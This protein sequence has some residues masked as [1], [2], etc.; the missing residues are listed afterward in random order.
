MGLFARRRGRA[1]TPE[2]ETP[3]IPIP[4]RRLIG[5]VRPYTGYMVIAFVA[6]VLSSLLSLV[7][8]AMIQRVVD[9]VLIA[10]DIALLDQ[11][12]IILLGVFL[13]RALTQLIETYTINY[14]GE[15]IVMNLR[16]ELYAHIVSLSLA[17]FTK[18]RAGELISRLSSDVTMIRQVLTDNINTLL[19][20]ILIAI[21][22]VVIMLA[23]NWR[24]TLFILVLV[25]ILGAIGGVI[26]T[27]LRRASTRIQDEIAGA[28]TVTTEVIQNIREVKTFVREP[29][30][31]TRYRT[32]IQ[33]AFNVAL[34]ALRLRSA[35]GS[36]IAF[37]A[38]GG[39]ALVLWF[40]GREAIAGR[41]SGGELIAFLIYG[42]SVAGSLGSLVA[43]YS[44]FQQ[45]IGATKRVFDI[46]AQ[47]PDIVDAP[48]ARPLTRTEGRITFDDVSFSYEARQQVLNN[49]N[50]DIAPGEILALVG[51]SGAGKSTVFN[52]IPRFYDPTQGAIS[53][54]GVDLRAITQASLRDQIG[55]VPQESLLFG[56]TIYEN[57]RYGRLDASE[58][59]VIA[60]AKAANAHDFIMELPD[61]Y[62]T[63]VGERG[64]RLSGGQRQRVS[65]A[66]ALLKDPRIL[67]LDEATSSLDSE[68][69]HEVQEALGRLMQGRTTVI[70]AHRL[71]TVR[72]AHRIAVLD[73]GSIIEL[74]T[75]EELMAVNGVY[76]RLYNM[77]FRDEPEAG[78]SEP[79]AS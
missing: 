62:Q 44:Q 6:L 33:R 72:I 34:E 20:Q 26:G 51:P 5:Y 31:V 19:Q 18:R 66:R 71:S 46:L 69:E 25:P 75:H 65:I 16:T 64:I 48:D 78:E 58:E 67:L 22:S 1:S 53:I 35:L 37:I 74:G 79:A 38:F 27:M 43:L 56:G 49:I 77:Q 59:Q 42:L 70:I 17:F 52:L 39:L 54:D 15:R 2:E 12:T 63:M 68:S 23:L 32:A 10:N 3:D 28:T 55:I 40:G 47:Q 60:A 7:F 30:E 29:Y 24:L 36:L 73:K 76:A 4:W 41:L 11:I 61:Q 13:L 14:V 50:L 21:G 57:I 45:G 9:S 8:P